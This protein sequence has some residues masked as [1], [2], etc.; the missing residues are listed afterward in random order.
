MTTANSRPL[1]LGLPNFHALANAPR[2]RQR[3]LFLFSF[4]QGIIIA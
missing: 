2:Q 3:L 1:I 4:H